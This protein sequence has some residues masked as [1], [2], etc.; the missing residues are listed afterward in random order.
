MAAVCARLAGPT[1]PV[2]EES[3]PAA[4]ADPRARDAAAAPELGAD[5]ADVLAELG[6]ETSA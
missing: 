6:L 4:V 2:P 5:T 1:V 3:G